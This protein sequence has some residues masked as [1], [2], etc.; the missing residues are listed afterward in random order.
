MGTTRLQRRAAAKYHSGGQWTNTCC[1]HPRPGEGTDAAA[2]RRLQE[3]MGLSVPLVPVFSFTYRSAFADGLWEHEFDHVYI[4]RTEA[5]PRPD[6]EEV[7]GWRWA[8]V[9][10]LAREIEAHPDHFTVWL[11]EP[12]EEIVARRAWE[13]LPG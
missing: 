4:G 6:P 11:R 1:S 9:D 3:E 7:A 2:G 12:F 5:E 8:S 10:D 13:A